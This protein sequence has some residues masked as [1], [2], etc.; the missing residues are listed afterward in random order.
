MLPVILN[1]EKKLCV[2]VGAGK[3]ALRKTKSLL[4]SGA[5]VRV[6]SPR[7]AKGFEELKAEKIC[8]E[9]EKDLIKGAFLVIT[10]TDDRQLN[11]QVIADAHDMGILV[12]S[13]T[14][15]NESDFYSCSV[16]DMGKLKIAVST[17]KSFPKLSAKICRDIEKE[18]RI[19]KDLCPI[20]EDYRKRILSE[21][22]D[23]SGELLDR[24]ISD[25]AIEIFRNGKEDYT[26]YIEEIL[27]DI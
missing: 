10:A 17:E 7:F 1:T 15:E 6:I 24:L 9:Y 4:E 27:K 14:A 3:T 11:S 16:A 21:N 25:K 13:V 2:V 5:F 19:Y 8:A 18:Y 12:S 23:N 22:R 26:K 20:L